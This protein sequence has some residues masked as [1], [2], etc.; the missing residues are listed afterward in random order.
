[1]KGVL[2]VPILILANIL[3][4]CSDNDNK[5]DAVRFYTIKT[6][7][8]NP[9]AT[10]QDKM[11]AQLKDQYDE[12][13]AC[14][15]GI[16]ESLLKIERK[17]SNFEFD[18]KQIVLESKSIGGDYREA[19]IAMRKKHKE[20][21]LLDYEMVKAERFLLNE[22]N[23]KYSALL[24]K[25]NSLYGGEKTNGNKIIYTGG[26]RNPG[27]DEPYDINNGKKGDSNSQTTLSDPEPTLR[28]P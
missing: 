7:A 21:I 19:V 24:D 9:V 5:S 13:Q 1:M 15:L 20:E 8:V 26:F 17:K 27:S 12:I 10:T 3:S 6:N 28:S 16:K 22:A 18:L 25:Y 23:S 4:G 2:L 11:Y 14:K